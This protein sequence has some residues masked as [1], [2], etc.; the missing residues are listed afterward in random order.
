MKNLQGKILELAKKENACSDQFARC[1][2]ATTERELLQ[3]VKDNFNWCYSRKVITVEIL[4]L[5]TPELII[6]FGIYHKGIY[7]KIQNLNGQWCK[8]IQNLVV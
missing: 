3:V 4:D 6:E 2:N 5:F 7:P 1:Q 8:R